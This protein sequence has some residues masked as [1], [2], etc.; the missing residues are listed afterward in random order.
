MIFYTKELDNLYS[1]LIDNFLAKM[2][3]NTKKYSLIYPS[4]TKD[5]N[6]TKLMVCGRATNGWFQ[7][8][9]LRSIKKKKEF[10]LSEAKESAQK[11]WSSDDF[12]GFKR[13]PFFRI[14]KRI[15]Q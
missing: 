15:L 1:E 10:I 13:K 5:Y 2:E 3:L 11:P 4:V 9:T 14:T 6:R 8:W 7:D 12:N